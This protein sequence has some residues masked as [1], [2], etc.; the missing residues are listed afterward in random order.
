MTSIEL[1]HTIIKT[2]LNISI[3]VNYINPEIP[4]YIMAEFKYHAYKIIGNFGASFLAPLFGASIV[5]QIWTDSISFEHSV[6]VAAITSLISTSLS[7]FN[8]LRIYG[9]T[10]GRKH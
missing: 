7:A 8:E 3:S 9:E 4:T 6:I 1:Y 10:D 5:N 2:G